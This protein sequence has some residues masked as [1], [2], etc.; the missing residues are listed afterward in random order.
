M[1]SGIEEKYVIFKLEN[2]FY[3]LNIKNVLSIEKVQQ[4]TRVPN[5]PSFVK[6]VINLR[7]EVIPIIDLKD[8]LGVSNI[9]IDSNTRIIVVSNKKVVVGLI[10][11]HS[12]EVLEISDDKIDRPPTTGENR[13][14]EYIKGVGKSDNRLI[15]MMDLEK[16]LEN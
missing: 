3:G 1:G 8:K 16:L 4:Y 2:E 5:A 10:V 15:M 11:E 7:G 12:S 6:G 13:F 9:Q 14:S